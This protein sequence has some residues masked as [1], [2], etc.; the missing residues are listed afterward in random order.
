M[1]QNAAENCGI[2]QTCAGDNDPY[3]LWRNGLIDHQFFCPGN[4][5]KVTMTPIFYK[6]YFTKTKVGRFKKFR[7]SDHPA[8]LVQYQ[9]EYFSR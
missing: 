3:N 5:G 1:P 4:S 2:R 6:H 8:V 7:L 9:I